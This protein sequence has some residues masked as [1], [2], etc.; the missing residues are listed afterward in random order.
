MV[1]H[2]RGWL[3]WSPAVSVA[4][5]WRQLGYVFMGEKQ[6]ISCPICV[7]GHL[8]ETQ[9]HGGVSKIS[10]GAQK[11]KKAKVGRGRNPSIWEPEEQKLEAS[12]RYLESLKPAWTT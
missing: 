11:I 10:N 1:Q 5:V 7:S 12:L 9:K 2:P 6:I 8:I 4:A 3:G